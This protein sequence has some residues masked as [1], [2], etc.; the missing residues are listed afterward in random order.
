MQKHYIYVA[1]RIKLAPAVSTKSNE[2]QG[3]LRLAISP[4]SNRRHSTEGVSQQNIHQFSSAC[5]NL[6]S[7]ITGLVP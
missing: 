2:R 1:E 6:A 3:H 7:A 4:N 5:A